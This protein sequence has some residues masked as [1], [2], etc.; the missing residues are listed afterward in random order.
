MDIETTGCIIVNDNRHVMGTKKNRLI[1]V[2]TDFTNENND[3]KVILK[4]SRFITAHEYGHFILH[5]KQ[6]QPLY[7]HRDVQHRKKRIELEAD[8]FAR[9]ILMPYKTFLKYTNIMRNMELSDDVCI[10][11]L[12]SIFKVTKDKVKKRISD[13]RDLEVNYDV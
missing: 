2:N 4:K 6:G 1:V 8:Y 3:D 7:A 11:L 13:I 9:S 5:K 10:Y 12:S